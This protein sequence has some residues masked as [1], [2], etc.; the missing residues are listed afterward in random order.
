MAELPRDAGI[1][2]DPARR[3]GV[4]RERA[5]APWPHTHFPPR[6]QQAQPSAP[7]HGRAHKPLPPVFGT[8]V[9]LRGLAGVLR[10]VAYRAPDHLVRHWLLLLL[11]DRVDWWTRRARRVLPFALPAVGAAVAAARSLSR[12]R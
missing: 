1:D 2:L 9:P 8:A 7:K 11:A 12:S 5:P 6:P 3:P 4:P 10:R